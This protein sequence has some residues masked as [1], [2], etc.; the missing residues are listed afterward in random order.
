MMLVSNEAALAF[1]RQWVEAF[2]SHDLEAIVSH[3]AQD[4][5]FTSPVVIRLLGEP[6]GVVN[7]KPALRAYFRKGL[8]ARPNLHFE[9]IGVLAGVGSIAV[10]YRSVDG[11]AVVEA[12]TLDSG[13]FVRRAEVY[14]PL[15]GNSV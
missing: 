12:M 6:S 8:A 11:Q 13:G 7:G 14:C 2:N 3:Y 15:I 4:V 10:H 9:L 1:G 5:E